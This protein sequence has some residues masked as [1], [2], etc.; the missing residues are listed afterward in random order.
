[1]I[2]ETSKN[3]VSVEFQGWAKKYLKKML[4]GLTGNL[5]RL[6]YPFNTNCWLKSSFQDGGLEGWWPYEQV[7]YWL[8][9]YVK[10]AYFSNDKKH[11]KKAK[12]MIDL[13]LQVVDE[14]GFVGAKELKEPG[15]GNQW[16]H[17]VFFRAVLF[18]YDITKDEKYLE[19]VKN[20]YLSGCSDYSLW[21]ESVNIENMVKCYLFSQDERLKVLAIKAYEKHCRNNKNKET[22]LEDFLSDKKIDLHAVTYNEMVKIPALLYLITAEKSY[23][24]A[25]ILGLKRIE[26][27]HMLPIGMHSASEFFGGTTADSCV[28]TCDISDHTWTLLWLAEITKNVEYLDRVERI[29]YNIAPS[30]MDKNF[31]ALQYYSSPNQVISTFNSN[32]SESFTGTPRMAYQANHYPE[33]CTGNSNRSIP[34]FLYKAVRVFDDEIYFNFYVEGRYLICGHEFVVETKY[35][36]EESV[37]ITYKGEGAKFKLKFRVPTWCKNFEFKS[38]KKLELK[39]NWLQIDDEFCDG[40]VIELK[41]CS[42]LEV[43]DTK[44]GFLVQ[45]QPIIY[46]LKIDE[47]VSIDKGEKRQ[48]KGYYAYNVVP[49]SKWQIALD[50]DLFLRTVRVCGK[51]VEDLIQNDRV[52]V[53][54]AFYMKGVDL[55]KIHSSKVFMSEYD[56]IEI[57]KLKNMNQTIY[58]GEM[59]FTPKLKDIKV[60]EYEQTKI[61]LVPYSTAM[62]RWTI[63]PKHK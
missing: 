41:I 56:K 1:M 38:D 35:P 63:F 12:Q 44:E 2:F 34:N 49:K 37:K 61:Q 18:L 17:A 30:V 19:K 59:L 32:H 31:K 39:N 28:E 8:D 62:L 13:A 26:K 47:S 33:C 11:F 27:Y 22:K 16:V 48:T 52:V 45:K 57:E 5:D 14:T 7:A 21:R 51:D 4:S 24:D 6:F 50:K 54:D 43:V 42:D 58:E 9:G 60:K 10:C 55:K 29:I 53:A 23:L 25:S 36:F 15:K 40:D 46:T 3:K 20:H